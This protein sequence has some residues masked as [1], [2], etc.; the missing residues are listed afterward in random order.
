MTSKDAENSIDVIEDIVQYILDGH[1][2]NPSRYEEALD[3]VPNLD[4]AVTFLEREIPQKIIHEIK[5][6]DDPEYGE[7][8]SCPNC[9]GFTVFAIEKAEEYPYCPHCGQ[10]LDWSD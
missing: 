8:W 10:K 7:L 5:Y 6:P 4:I 3:V 9:L 2:R 1:E